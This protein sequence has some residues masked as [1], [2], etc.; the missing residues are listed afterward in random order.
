NMTNLLL[1][2]QNLVGGLGIGCVYALIALGFSLIY[3]AMGLINFAQGSLLM[4]GT[5]LGLTF[6]MGL[7]GLNKFSPTIAFLIGILLC[8]VLG[9]ALERLFRPLAELDL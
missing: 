4:F 5:Y 9:I 8:S 7:L 2:V 3:R 1:I 6:Y